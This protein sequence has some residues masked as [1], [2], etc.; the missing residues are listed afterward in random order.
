M[1]IVQDAENTLMNIIY[2]LNTDRVNYRNNITKNLVTYQSKLIKEYENRTN[3]KK[4]EDIERIDENIM[5]LSMI[6][7][8]LNNF[9]KRKC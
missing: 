4:K 7:N 8:Q 1:E 5:Y 3:S 9:N 2:Q 6:V